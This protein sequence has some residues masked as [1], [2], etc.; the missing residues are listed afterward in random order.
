MTGVTRT[1][2]VWCADWPVVAAGVPLD[3]PAAVFHANRVVA[4]SPAA[5]HEGVE[6][7]QRRRDAQARCPDLVVLERD[8]AAEARAFEP[9]PA[10]LEALTPRIE[11]THPGMCAF[12][13]RGPS[14]YHGGDRALA[15]RATAVVAE[16][17]AGRG[18]VQVGVADGPFAAALAARHRGAP[19]ARPGLLVA[20]PG[21]L[22]VGSGVPVAGVRVRSAGSG[23]PGAGPGSGGAAVGPGTG[24]AAASGLG[25]GSRSGG[26]AAGP[27]AGSG[28][29]GVG[30]S[31][32]PGTG[33]GAAAG[34]RGGTG[35]G[36][37]GESGVPG[38]G[39][40]SGGGAAA[41]P[42]VGSGSSGVA[43]AGPGSGGVAA[44]PVVVP[45]GASPA[46]LA[47]LPVTVLAEPGGLDAGRY[48]RGVR[49]GEGGAYLHRP[50]GPELVDVFERLG[51][52]TLGDLAALPVAE[53]VGRFGA[54]GRVAH[55]LA[56]GLDARPPVTAPPPDE[57]TVTAEIDPPAERVEA[58]AFVARGLVDDLQARLTT[59]GSACTRL[60]IGAETEHGETHERVWRTEGTFTAPAIAARVRWQLDG[61]LRAGAHRPTGGLSRL[62]LAPDEIVP[63]GGRQLAF[64]A[65]GPGSVDP[66]EAGDRAARALARVQGL[67]GVEAVR[68]PEWRGGRGPGE[69]VGLVPVA[70]G[71]ITEP[72]PAAQAGWVAEPW[73]GLVPD[74]APATVHDPPLPAEVV[75]AAGRP[76]RVSG[77]GEISAAPATVTIRP[78]GAASR[79]PGAAGAAARAAGGAGS[80]GPGA[81]SRSPGAAGRTGSP[82][83][84]GAKGPAG[85][86]EP[87]ATSAGRSPPRG[88]QVAVAAWAGP[89]PY[90][91]RWWDPRGHRRRARL[92][93]ATTDGVAYLLA[94]ESGRWSVEATYD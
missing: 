26:A 11:I 55:R 65:G 57:L 36:G 22:V 84:A 67:L 53:V 33:G 31:G 39:P 9:V 60:V 59:R 10:A 15:E 88:R 73:P 61:W 7:H 24:G 3:V 16:V 94:V 5:R 56:G 79:S 89:W 80:S 27:R 40:G 82:G 19:E 17:L 74:P 66:V 20:G 49:G 2:V 68:V 45:P 1:L 46:F 18:P 38:A 42:G 6:R 71:D 23:V 75:D 29:G 44:E 12:P 8:P 4:C 47:P 35:T 48:L 62:W 14:R 50:V 58:A 90:D 78:P 77:R 93:V 70:A 86:A 69:Q 30:E 63:A 76:V 41:G 83:S 37:L 54:E 34:P 28:T 52:R 91:E 43:A 81:A 51:V 92:Q 64:S 87:A 85:A 32:V 25:V 13:T 21:S 72:R